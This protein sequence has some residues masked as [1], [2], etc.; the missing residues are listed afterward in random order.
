MRIFN[1]V[2]IAAMAAF[3][4]AAQAQEIDWKKVDEAF[5]RSPVVAGDVH[6]YNFPRT[7]LTVASP[8]GPLSRWAG[9]PPSSLCTAG[10]W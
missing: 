7:D 10:S 3:C 9:G 2:T 8:S 5:G 6:R 4:C 1:L